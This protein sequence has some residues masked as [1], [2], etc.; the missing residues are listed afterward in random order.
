MRQFTALVLL[1]A[2]NPGWETIYDIISLQKA[3]VRSISWFQWKDYKSAVYTFKNHKPKV[4]LS[5]TLRNIISNVYTA[6]FAP[7]C[8]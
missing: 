7:P 2:L 3:L 8:V 1:R 5:Y 4:S 6:P